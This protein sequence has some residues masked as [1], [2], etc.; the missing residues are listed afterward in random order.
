MTAQEQGRSGWRERL[1]RVPVLG[2]LVA[3]ARGMYSLRVWRGQ[4]RR[5]IVA[6]R[7]DRDALRADVAALRRDLQ[8]L[9]PQ[10]LDQRREIDA[11]VEHAVTELARRLESVRL[12]DLAARDDWT[13]GLEASLEARTRQAER[14][15]ATADAQAR[16]FAGLT[17]RLRAGLR[18]LHRAQADAAPACAL[19]VGSLAQALAEL[20]ADTHAAVWQQALA[21][22]ADGVPGVAVVVLPAGASSG[23]AAALRDLPEQS[24]DA[25]LAPDGAQALGEA[26][27]R[28]L[29]ATAAVA[30]KPAGCLAV[31]LDNPENAAVALALCAASPGVIAW[32]PQALTATWS[33]SGVEPPA[34]WR[35]DADDAPALAGE[36]P[37]LDALNRLLGGS[38]RFVAVARRGD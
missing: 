1:A 18:G 2:N 36:G 35:L 29:A 7:D 24:L 34:I 37:G 28:E 9:E 23:W 10:R 27:M 12:A 8:A 14:R 32:T 15:I 11:H 26:A 22:A 38:R 5:D 30:L 17:A 3:G 19:R 31:R 21:M 16:E 4:L 13:R 33:S 25:I 6:L 20:A